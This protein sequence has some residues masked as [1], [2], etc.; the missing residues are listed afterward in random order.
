MNSFNKPFLTSLAEIL[1]R[2]KKI[3]FKDVILMAKYELQHERPNCI[4]CS[5]CASVAPD[6][7]KMNDDG[8]SDVI[9]G[10][11]VAEGATKKEI[12]EK[13]L[14]VNKTAAESCPVNVIHL[15]N[16]ETGQKII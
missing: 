9:G 14:P 10:E 11:A 1:V 15:I 7:W 13:D 4:G 2:L 12:D 6:F 16:K 8:K 5:A 3:V